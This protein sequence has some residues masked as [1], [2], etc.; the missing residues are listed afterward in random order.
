MKSSV[1]LTE[2][3]AFWYWMLIESRPSRSMSNPESL[4]TRALC[5][6]RA[7]HQMK[8]RT[9][10]W[11]TFSTTILAALR[12]LP[13]LLMVP[14]EESAPRMNDTGPDASPPLPSGSFEERMV[15]RL[16]PAPEPP[17][18]HVPVEDG[19]HGVLDRQDEAV[20]HPHVVR[21]VFAAVGL[22][23]VDRL[24]A[25][26]LDREDLLFAQVRAGLAVEV[27]RSR[28]PRCLVLGDET[29]P[30]GERGA[31][32]AHVDLDLMEIGAVGASLA[33]PQPPRVD[34]EAQQQHLEVLGPTL[35]DRANRDTARS[36]L[37]RDVAI[38]LEDAAQV[39]G[40]DLVR[41]RPQPGRHAQIVPARHQAPC[42]DE[43][44]QDLAVEADTTTDHALVGGVEG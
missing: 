5:S 8:S 23:I 18:L 20:V 33:L 24:D 13:P 12:V 38:G 9:S 27:E 1:T 28:E 2:L 19:G 4:S 35:A 39:G 17:F 15:D 30:L 36:A 40:D 7:L 37:H 6:S 14:A 26:V 25:P 43:R 3:F 16:M 21:E 32:G 22:D 34:P 10:G 42:L 29:D 11:S 44:A 31:L 41:S